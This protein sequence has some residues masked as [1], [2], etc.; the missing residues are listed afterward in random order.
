MSMKSPD[1]VRSELSQ[2]VAE[3]LN[4]DNPNALAE[5]LAEFAENKGKEILEE[6]R[7]YEKTN[8]SSILA[9]RG[10]RQLTSDEKAFYESF[11]KAIKTGD[12][13]QSFT[14]NTAAWPTT[15]V[16]DVTEGIRN[17]FELLDAID[18][19]IST[20]VTKFLYNKQAEQLA[21]W[22]AFGTKVE[23]ELNGAIGVL[24]ISSVK[25][26]AKIPVSMDFVEAGTEWLDAYVRAI[27]VE[28]I[29][30][31]M[32]AAVADGTGK[33]MPIGMSRDCSDTAVV[34]AGVYP[35]KTKIV[36]SDLGINTLA[37]LF[38]ELAIDE[39]GRSRKIKEATIIV[40]PVDEYKKIIPEF[41]V[42]DLNGNYVMKPAFP[43][44][45]ISEPTVEANSAIFGIAD[46]YILRASLGDRT[47]KSSF[48][49]SCKFDDDM[50]VFKNKCLANGRPKGANDF[51]FL[52]ITAVQAGESDDD[53]DN[54]SG[55]GESGGGS[56]ENNPG[57]GESGGGGENGGVG[58]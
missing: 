42:R 24:D 56:G 34:T 35:Q 16:N 46:K 52:D 11:K 33:D 39:T 17:S 18:F 21:G 48:D 25:L 36:V 7:M 14:V 27:L 26:L 51:L 3:A 37:A 45:V 31:A 40:N 53:D 1:V 22:G 13:K 50:R 43:V 5:V 55:G 32:C 49:D 29:G 30:C 41:S 15:I 57:G 47:G 58:A 38:A 28:A 23:T 20:T 6:M 10:I 4:S 19:D 54:N 2:K 44:K 12:V 9:A 8:D